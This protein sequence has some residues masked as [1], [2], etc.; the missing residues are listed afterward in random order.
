MKDLS[1]A[2]ETA[3]R[4]ALVRW[5][6][7]LTE[8][9]P[10][11]I[12]RSAL[13]FLP[14]QPLILG[15]DDCFALLPAPC[16]LDYA[17]RFCQ[18]FEEAMREEFQKRK[19]DSLGPPPTM[20][21]AV[22]IC[23]ASYPYRLAHQRGEQLLKAAKRFT[24]GIARAESG[25]PRS[26]VNFEVILGNAIGSA[27]AG[28][29]YRPSMRPY[30]ITSQGL[31]DQARAAG[32]SLEAL[33]DARWQLQVLPA[34]RRSELRDLYALPV[35][36]EKPDDLPRWDARLVRLRDRLALGDGQQVAE[37]TNCLR[38]LGSGNDRDAPGYWRLLLREG[39][40]T[41]SAQGLP[42]VLEAWDYALDLAREPNK[43][44]ERER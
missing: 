37:L 21:A 39:E 16:A 36:P 17:R 35:L 28:G 10:K 41:V 27:E 33:L 9:L 32:V 1:A 12:R 19:L 30:W 42:D 20:S 13:D 15:G 22:V 44:E 6:P 4:K 2:L 18:A 11:L 14:L 43:Y 29:H 3:S 38:T 8:W 34:K 40:E 23:K 24:K 7:R 25:T 5:L 31:S 26:V